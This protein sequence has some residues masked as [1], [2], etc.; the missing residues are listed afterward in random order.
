MKTQIKLEN[1][2]GVSTLLI[3]EGRMKLFRSKLACYRNARQMLK[4]LVRQG[5]MN[6]L[7]LKSAK[8][9]YQAKGEFAKVNFRPDEADW[10]MLR[11]YA[12]SARVSMVYLFVWLMEKDQGGVPTKPKKIT[13]HYQLTIPTR[14]I[15]LEVNRLNQ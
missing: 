3:P 13:L 2:R 11:I 4:A 6:R 12:F 15:Y 8:I 1:N 9:R 10:E 7:K 5:K 14:E